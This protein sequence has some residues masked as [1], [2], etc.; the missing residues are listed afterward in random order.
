MNQTDSISVVC[1]VV[2][3]EHAAQ[4]RQQRV[5][6]DGDEA[7]HEEQAGEQRSTPCGKAADRSRRSPAKQ[8]SG[9]TGS[10]HDRPLLAVDCSIICRSISTLAAS[11]GCRGG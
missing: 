1:G 5:V 2:E 10:C 7:P 8:L 6:D 3:I 11:M 9:C 4:V